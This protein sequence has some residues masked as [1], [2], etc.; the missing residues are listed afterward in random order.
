MDSV[1][2]WP[3]YSLQKTGHLTCKPY[4][5]VG[6]VRRGAL[7]LPTNFGGGRTELQLVCPAENDSGYFWVRIWESQ[8]QRASPVENNH[9]GGGNY[10]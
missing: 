9:F 7:V 8:Q 5:L 6:N 4:G 1:L 10:Y 3:S 2:W